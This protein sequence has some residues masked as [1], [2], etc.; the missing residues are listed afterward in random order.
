MNKGIYWAI[1]KITGYSLVKKSYIL[2]YGDKQ[3]FTASSKEKLNTAIK[4]WNTHPYK[5][6]I[7]KR[8]FNPGVQ[9]NF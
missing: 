7:Y 9:Q 4:K 8:G 5:I 6:K 1:V 3:T 2:P